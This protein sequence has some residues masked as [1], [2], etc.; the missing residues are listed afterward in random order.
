MLRVEIPG[1]RQIPDPEAEM[2]RLAAL[3]NTPHEPELITALRS[4]AQR[5]LDDGDDYVYNYGRA[6]LDLLPTDS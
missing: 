1:A 3:R 6:L 2:E 5:M 4:L